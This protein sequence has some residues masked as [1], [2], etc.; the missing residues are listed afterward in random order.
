MNI[1]VGEFQHVNA[2]SAFGHRT[3]PLVVH[4]W[5]FRWI[6]DCMRKSMSDLRVRPLD[7][8]INFIIC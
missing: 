7:D 6:K 2:I 3:S 1:V 8:F 4:S 5:R